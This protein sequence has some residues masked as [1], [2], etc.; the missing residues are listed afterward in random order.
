[1][2]DRSEAV[3]P[4]PRWSRRDV[5]AV[6]A[7]VLGVAVAA[8]VPVLLCLLGWH[9]AQEVRGVGAGRGVFTA[10][11]CGDRQEHTTET[12]NG[13]VTNVTY[14][15]TGTFDGRSGSRIDAS[16]S[17]GYDYRPGTRTAAYVT[18]GSHVH[19]ADHAR[20]AARMAVWFT[21]ACAVACLEVPVVWGLGRWIRGTVPARPGE[22]DHWWLDVPA[23]LIAAV[24]FSPF[25]MVFWL[26][27]FAIF[28]ILYVFL[29]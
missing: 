1:M 8:V 2:A 19:L 6:V 14:T 10:A 24:F 28:A 4:A 29:S 17:S 11:S 15:C 26:V 21:A 18:G 20:A 25:I 13:P 22:P 5:N 7:V 27:A 16:V 12:E 23:M 9:Q 3:N